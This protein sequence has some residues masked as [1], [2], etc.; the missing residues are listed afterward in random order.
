MNLES[1]QAQNGS[2]RRSHRA[3]V[4]FPSFAKGKFM[5][6]AKAPSSLAP[7]VYWSHKKKVEFYQFD[8]NY[9]DH[10]RGGDS[11][12]ERHF[13]KYFG[14]RL[15]A[16]LLNRGFATATLEDISQETFLR[17]FSAVRNGGI[18]YPERF[19][20][21][22]NSVCDKVILE[23]YREHAKHQHLDVDAMELPDG[24]TNLETIVLR[25]E[26][27]K[28]V[29]DLLDQLPV[30]KRN[31]LRAWIFEQ[32]DREQLC[33]KFK[34]KNDYLRVLLFRAKEDFAALCKAK[35]LDDLEDGARKIKR[36]TSV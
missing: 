26:K 13:A 8:A 15:R 36:A 4:F 27:K 35:G 18:L 29:A 22:V 31:I 20:A 21:Y 23:K 10:L 34:V 25:K 12:T 2:K 7:E 32:L 33:A 5:P 30:K 16:K 28:I 6:V 11:E 14:E 19:G 17:V 1:I 3:T 24:K 9:L